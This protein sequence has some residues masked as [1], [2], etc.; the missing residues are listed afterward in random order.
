MKTRKKAVTL[1]EISIGIVISALIFVALMNLFSAGMKG[2]TKGLAHQD[3]MQVA[4]LLMSQIEYDLLRSTEILSPTYG[5]S[6]NAAQWKLCYD[7]IDNKYA[8]V[9]YTSEGNTV[10]RKVTLSNNKTEKINYGKDNKVK[11]EFTHFATNVADEKSGNQQYV[12]A[13]WVEVTVASKEDKK[14]G[15]ANK[16]KKLGENEITLKRLVILRSQ[17]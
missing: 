14:I 12:R 8:T 2:S 7:R 15:E 1:I 4:S 5:D 9:D 3:N 10:A 11:V 16:E 13:M 17:N 6:D